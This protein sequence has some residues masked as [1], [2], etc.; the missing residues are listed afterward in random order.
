MELFRGQRQERGSAPGK[1]N[2][3]H[4]SCWATNRHIPEAE[5]RPERTCWS[6]RKVQEIRE[7]LRLDHRDVETEEEL[8]QDYEVTGSL[9]EG[10]Y[11]KF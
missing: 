4:K 1:M 10:E 7:T 5:G 11:C 8:R 6:N 9:G 2:S 3:T